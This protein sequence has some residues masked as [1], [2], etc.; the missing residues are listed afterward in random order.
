MIEISKKFLKAVSPELFNFLRL[1]SF[2][3]KLIFYP[4]SYL[5]LTGFLRSSTLGKPVSKDNEPLPWMNYSV[6]E[7]LKQRLNKNM[8]LFEY[9]SGYSTL[10]FSKLVK[11]V[12][13]VECNKDWYELI[14]KEGLNENIISLYQELDYDGKYCT[15]IN[16]TDDKYQV[17]V[18]DGRDRIRCAI[19]AVKNLS[20]DGVIIFDDTHRERYIE[21]C[22]CLLKIGFKKL[23]FEGLK[24][25]GFSLHKTSIFYKKVNCFSI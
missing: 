18:I 5:N 9:G 3:I 4:D 8:V 25:I 10:F 23:D 7:F 19:N 22:D 16:E 13:S 21:G 24:P 2:I 1:T 15:K 12:V 6:I 17:V 20:E 14:S 11:K